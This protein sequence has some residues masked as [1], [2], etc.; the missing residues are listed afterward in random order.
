MKKEIL[1][2]I[3]GL[4][5]TVLAF[6]S[7]TGNSLI[8]TLSIDIDSISYIEEEKPVDLGFDTTLYLPVDFDA[9]GVPSHFMDVSYIEEEVDVEFNFNTRDYLPRAFDPYKEY[10]DL[11]SIPF[12]EDHDIL[13][14]DYDYMEVEPAEFSPESTF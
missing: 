13:E 3:A 6:G 5:V 1:T 4:L 10:F 7:Q 2:G 11:N 12:I 9:Y 14:W 8:N